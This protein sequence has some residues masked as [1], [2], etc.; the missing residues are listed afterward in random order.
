[1]F[2]NKGPGLFYHITLLRRKDT[3]IFFDSKFIRYL[4]RIFRP[5]TMVDDTAVGGIN[6][7]PHI[8]THID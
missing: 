4:F 8:D 6:L 3:Q 7:F 2:H 5:E 1:M